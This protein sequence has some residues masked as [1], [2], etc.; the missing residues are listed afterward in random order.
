[1]PN[2]KMNHVMDPI[3]A[4]GE[5]LVVPVVPITFS[6]TVGE[7]MELDIRGVNDK[8]ILIK[9]T[10]ATNPL[11]YQIMASLDAVDRPGD[12]TY[13]IVHKSSTSVAKQTQAL[14]KFPDYYNFLR[15]QVKSALGSSAEI[16]VAGTGN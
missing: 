16:K 4:F 1:M 8:S 10:G 12:A 2:R 14:E 9:N 6:T 7:F 13:D 15:I 5:E 3:S 11:D